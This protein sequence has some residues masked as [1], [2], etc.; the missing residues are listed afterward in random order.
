VHLERAFPFLF[1]R[2]IEE[3]GS[4]TINFAKA[5]LTNLPALEAQNLAFLLSLEMNSFVSSLDS[6]TFHLFVPPP[7]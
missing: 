2:N 3:M 1:Q 5:I 6:N 7:S 4:K